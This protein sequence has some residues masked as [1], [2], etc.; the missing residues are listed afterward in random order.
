MWG[1]EE[2]RTIQRLSLSL[3][4][5][6]YQPA[7]NLWTFL[8][9]CT[10]VASLLQPSHLALGCLCCT[11]QGNEV[12][13]APPLQKNIL[14]PL[15][16]VP[17][18]VAVQEAASGGIIRNV[19]GTSWT[20]EVCFWSIETDGKSTERRCSRGLLCLPRGHS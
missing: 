13:Y 15:L 4:T 20:V 14:P 2:R 8:T 5:R 11:P 12:Q 6:G 3:R 7:G 18:I 10:D 1:R 9:F 19:L 16:S 17:A